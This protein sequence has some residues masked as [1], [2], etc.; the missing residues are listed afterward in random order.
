[1]T[2]QLLQ[3]LR[4]AARVCGC[5]SYYGLFCCKCWDVVGDK[6]PDMSLA[7]KHGLVSFDECDV[8]ALTAAGEKKLTELEKE[9]MTMPAKKATRFKMMA[10]AGP[11]PLRGKKV[12]ESFHMEV[13]NHTSLRAL[14]DLAEKSGALDLSK[15]TLDAESVDDDS[16]SVR[17]LS[18]SPRV[19]LSYS[20]TET[21]EDFKAR[22]KEWEE[23]DK[24][25]KAWSKKYAKEILE[26]NKAAAAAATKRRLVRRV[27][28]LEKALKEEQERLEKMK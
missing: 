5:E 20:P 27:R 1:M 6:V 2:A 13:S 28:D 21:E 15:V 12:K 7:L 26:Y 19:Y 9:E 4:F 25:Y 11:R 10:P 22:L 24:A 17:S 18:N 3:A 8:P 23:K 14:I 16:Y